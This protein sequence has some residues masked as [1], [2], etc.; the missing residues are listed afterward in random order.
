MKR[1]LI[2]TL[3]LSACAHQGVK[4]KPI[5]QPAATV[6]QP[7]I[8]STTVD[9]PLTECKDEYLFF[10]IRYPFEGINAL[11]DVYDSSIVLNQDLQ[12]L[13]ELTVKFRQG[14][15]SQEEFDQE[16]ENLNQET[17]S[18]NQAIGPLLMKYSTIEQTT[19]KI[20]P[21]CQD[22]LAEI[23]KSDKIDSNKDGCELEQ[24]NAYILDPY[25]LKPAI[26][27]G[28]HTEYLISE[29]LTSMYQTV[30]EESQNKIKL[31]DARAQFNQQVTELEAS[32]LTKQSLESMNQIVN[33]FKTTMN[34]KESCE[35][36]HKSTAKVKK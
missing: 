7:E 26:N 34:V 16:I 2:F 17:A 18:V 14:V 3:L 4:E 5:Q 27:E 32:G 15:I 31:E 22:R 6:G 1:L 28:I 13:I 11:K 30:W 29:K 25:A 21:V 33:S 8:L 36:K 23:M 35:Q 12:D 19:D 20:Y 10:L 9:F 24:Q